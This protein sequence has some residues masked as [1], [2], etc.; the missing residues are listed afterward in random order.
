MLQRISSR[1]H[2]PEP[3][4][5]LAMPR[6]GCAAAPAPRCKSIGKKGSPTTARKPA[7]H[8]VKRSAAEIRLVSLRQI[9]RHAATTAPCQI[10]VTNMTPAVRENSGEAVSRELLR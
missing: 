4:E 5:E 3:A 10:A 9:V 6:A 7:L 8:T 2:G 1:S